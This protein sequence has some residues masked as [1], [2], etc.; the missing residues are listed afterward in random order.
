MEM[1]VCFLFLLKMCHCFLNGTKSPGKEWVVLM[2]RVF[3]FVFLF[4]S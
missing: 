3:S 4:F 2:F 1:E